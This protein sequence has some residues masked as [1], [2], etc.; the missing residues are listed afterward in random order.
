MVVPRVLQS[1]EM[2]PLLDFSQYRPVST[3][4]SP[5]QP[6]PGT[7]MP[8]ATADVREVSEMPL[9]ANETIVQP[10]PQDVEQS[11]CVACPVPLP[12][13][14]PPKLIDLGGPSTVANSQVQT[15]AVNPSVEL[16][17]TSEESESPM[18]LIQPVPRLEPLNNQEWRELWPELTT[19]LRHLLQPAPEPTNESVP[20]VPTL[21]PTNPATDVPSTVQTE[22]QKSSVTVQEYHTAADESPLA[23]EALLSRPVPSEMIERSRDF[24]RNLLDILNRVVPPVP[25]LPTPPVVRHQASFVSDNNIA[26]GQIFPPGAEFVKSWVMCNNGTT[27]WPEET[28]L[29]YVA[30]DTMPSRAGAALPVAVGCVLPGAEVELVAGEMKVRIHSELM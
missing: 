12:I 4:D 20:V 15:P 24:G 21:V 16:P 6:P 30:G 2:T 19:V 29:R 18:G 9:F 17:E 28:T 10:P 3:P 5:I 7:F 14:P 11:P 25:R 27:A 1:E 8:I 22:S 26:D 23:G 13:S